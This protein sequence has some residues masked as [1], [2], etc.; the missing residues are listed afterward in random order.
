MTIRKVDTDFIRKSFT[1]EKTVLDY[2]KAV[3]EIGL[4]ESEKMM[5]KKY[6]N[7]ENRILD[8]GCGAGRTSIGLYKLGYHLI[9]GL[10]LSEAMI[11][12]ARRISKELK[13]DITFSVGDAACLDYDDETF[14]VALFSFNGIMQ[15]PGKE[16]RIKVL[17][18][19]KRILKSEGYFLF[20]THDRDSGKEYESFWQ[21]EK[22]KW[23]LHIQDKSLHEFGDRVIKME[24]R[25]TFLHFPTREEVISCLKE[26]GFVL[27]ERILRSVLCEESEEVKKFSTDCVLWLV[28]KPLKL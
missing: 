25:D 19:I 12:Q 23:A 5:I 8:I 10:D 26:A 3:R 6:F 17:K 21:E 16:N 22:K 1:T 27:I 14:E 24:E 18:E 2:T 7:P 11:A 9:E 28:H 4:W 20:T 13:Y 15:I